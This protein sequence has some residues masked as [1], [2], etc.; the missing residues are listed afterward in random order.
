LPPH[1]DID[2]A[3]A[4]VAGRRVHAA[5]RGNACVAPVASSTKSFAKT[6][7]TPTNRR[8]ERATVAR[9]MCVA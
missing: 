8:G 5:R 4:D 2:A 7:R 3:R 9:S 1:F 6:L